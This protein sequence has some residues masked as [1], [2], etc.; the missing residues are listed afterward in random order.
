MHAAEEKY[1]SNTHCRPIQ[2]TKLVYR[3]LSIV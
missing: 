1:N 2:L 3:F